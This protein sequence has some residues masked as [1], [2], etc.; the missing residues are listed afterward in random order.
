MRRHALSATLLAGVSAL[1]LA[2]P[3]AALVNPPACDA[4]EPRVRCSDFNPGEVYRV[5]APAGE[6]ATLVFAPGSEV[7][8]ISGTRV[9]RRIIQRQADGSEKVIEPTE[10]QVEYEANLVYL[11]P[12]KDVPTTFS[13]IVVRM[14]DGT[15]V[16][17]AFELNTRPA[18]AP[19][20]L[21]SADGDAAA[22]FAANKDTM[23]MLTFRY[24]RIEAERRAAEAAAAAAARRA[25]DAA[26]A[27]QRAEA[28]RLSD[29]QFAADRLR[30]D[31]LAGPEL[32]F[33]WRCQNPEGQ[34]CGNEEIR[35]RGLSSNGMTVALRFDPGQPMP[36]PYRLEGAE[37]CDGEH[38]SILNF[39]IP[40]TGVLLVHGVPGRICLRRNQTVG[41]I[42]VPVSPLGR[43]PATGTTSPG[44][45]RTLRSA[46]R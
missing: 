19:I 36:V 10:W 7:L 37:E 18:S 21:A 31:V 35:P 26:S 15:L 20:A 12:L 13:S 4:A 33:K 27:V 32:P 8:T 11:T 16:P 3:A 9:Q 5:I 30:Q 29:Q 39:S 1:A 25:Q 34:P 43:N 17:H 42:E 38:E 46:S 40:A 23:L 24:P 22:R 45:V 44:V 6:S 14:P 28:R 41:E 2:W